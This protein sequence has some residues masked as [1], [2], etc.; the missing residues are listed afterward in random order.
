A[1]HA[2]IATDPQAAP[3]RNAGPLYG[4]PILL[5]DNI[6]A[7]G[8]ATTAG[9]LALAGNRPPDDAFLVARL[10]EA[11]AVVVGKTN[12]PEWANVRGDRSSSGWSAVGGQTHNPYALDRSPCG[13]SSGSAVAVAAGYVPLAVATETDGSILCP[14][15]LN[16]I[17][18]LKP[19]VGLVSRDG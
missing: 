10:R 4:L 5:K 13:S 7:V 8:F 16:G 17:V 19:T 6:D 11:G 14:A 1:L 3:A 2:V 12:L 18:G 15:S 9:S